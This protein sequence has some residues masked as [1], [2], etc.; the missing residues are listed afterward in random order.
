MGNTFALNGSTIYFPPHLF[1]FGVRPCGHHSPS[2][3]FPSAHQMISPSISHIVFD[4][5]L[6]LIAVMSG[7]S[8]NQFRLDQSR[9]SLRWSYVNPNS[10]HRMGRTTLNVSSTVG[11]VFEAVNLRYALSASLS[12]GSLLLLR[13]LIS[14]FRFGSCLNRIA[15]YLERSNNPFTGR[16]PVNVER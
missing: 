15:L 10:A 2:A 5:L 1:S 14:L 8:R 3:S 11:V 13:F 7:S 12:L 4:S 16:A 6:N 9:V